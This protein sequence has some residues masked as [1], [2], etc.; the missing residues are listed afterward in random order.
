MRDERLESLT[1]LPHRFQA[2]PIGPHIPTNRFLLFSWKPI[3][4]AG[5]G[6][7]PFSSPAHRDG[8]IH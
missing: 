8:R 3:A 5:Q 7:R 4:K 1:G 6:L 2:K